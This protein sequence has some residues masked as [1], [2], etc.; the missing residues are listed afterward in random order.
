MI[1]IVSHRGNIDGPSSEENSPHQIEKA[2]EMFRV[3]V[4]VWYKSGNWFLGHNEPVYEIGF[5]FFNKKMFLHCKNIKAV[6]NLSNTCYNWFWHESD[7]LT[8]TSLGEIWCYPDNYVENGIT[9]FKGVPALTWVRKLPT[10]I[11]GICTDY[12]LRMGKLINGF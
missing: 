11:K 9:V 4:D 3:E 8:L 12:P 2:L 10:D 7:Q 5:E 6:K 1:E